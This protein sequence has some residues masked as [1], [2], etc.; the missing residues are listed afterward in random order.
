MRSR[1]LWSAL[2]A[3]LLA[4]AGKA[5]PVS[6]L[7]LFVPATEADRAGQ[8]VTFKP[9]AEIS[10]DTVLVDQNGATYAWQ[11][12]GDDRATLLLPLLRA[13]E[14]LTLAFHPPTA[15]SREEKRGVAVT[16]E[17][18]R[19]AVKVAGAPA[20]YYLTD[21]TALPRSD[22]PKKFE[23]AG[24]LHPVLTPTG[25]RVTD[26]FP[27]MHVHHHG[28]WAAWTKTRFQGRTP[29]FWN[30]G[31]E[32][33][34]VEFLAVDRPWS[35]AVH[36][37]FTARHRYVD[38]S[39]KPEP[40]TV[41]NE[42]WSIRAYDLGANGPNVRVFDLTLRQDAITRDP[43][44]LLEYHYGGLGFRGRENWNGAPN[45]CVLT[46]EGETDRVK[47]QGQ[48]VRWIAASGPAE[49]GVVT[50]AMLGHPENFR[51]PQPLR[52]H[53]DEPFIGYTPA[54]LGD[55]KIEPGKPHVARYRFVVS[56]GEP[57][58]KLLD[59]FWNGFANEVSAKAFGP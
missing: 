46:S 33:G 41:L 21:K 3:G 49:R 1:F 51:A 20:F 42:E 58:A 43:L 24:Y 34:L 54:P 37:G 15:A 8:V 19:L 55:F 5:A 4:V 26:D 48:R 50:F 38:L 39:A 6:S 12:E 52:V 56:D 9:I 53:P 32:K 10:S 22:I 11:K 47:A 18:Q 45:L 35:G 14:K 59:A 16:A 57:D 40:V 2:T 28:V 23:R 29:D 36:G 7:R 13:G 44:E 31:D 30:M 17:A 25:Q 27:P